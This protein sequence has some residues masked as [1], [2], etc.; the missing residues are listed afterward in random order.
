MLASLHLIL[1]H[2][3][4]IFVYK[5]CDHEL[6]VYIVDKNESKHLIYERKETSNIREGSQDST[7][8]SMMLYAFR[9]VKV[10]G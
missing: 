9:V 4:V 3:K 10:E 8:D 7:S 6:I 1:E 5:T 2:V